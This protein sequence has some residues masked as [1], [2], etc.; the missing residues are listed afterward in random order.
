M[1][2]GDCARWMTEEDRYTVGD[3]NPEPDPGL[4]SEVPI[5]IARP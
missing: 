4:G 5:R 1:D 3:R 2:Q